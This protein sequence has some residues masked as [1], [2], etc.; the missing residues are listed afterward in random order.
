MGHLLGAV[1]QDCARRTARRGAE[2]E[3]PGRD[4]PVTAGRRTGVRAGLYPPGHP[5]SCTPP[6]A[7][8]RTSKPPR[9]TMCTSGS[10]PTTGAPTRCWSWPATS[11]PGTSRAKVEHYFRGAPAGEPLAGPVQ[12][13]PDLPANSRGGDAR[14]RPARRW[15]CAPGRCPEPQPPRHGGLLYL[16]ANEA[17]SGNRNVASTAAAGGR[18]A[19]GITG[20]SGSVYGLSVNGEYHLHGHRVGRTGADPAEATAVKPTRIIGR[21]SRVGPGRGHPG[22]LEASA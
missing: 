3:A 8:W 7:R 20:V 4:T 11:P 6:S 22:Q 18:V 21:I 9:S 17:L 10:T 13:I 1:D 5:Y 2:R 14:P 19:A 16:L 12:W 15:W